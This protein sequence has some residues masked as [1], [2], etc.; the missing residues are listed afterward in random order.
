MLLTIFCAG[1]TLLQSWRM[2]SLTSIIMNKIHD[3]YSIS[4]YKTGTDESGKEW[5]T[6]CCVNMNMKFVYSFAGQN[7]IG[8]SSDKCDNW[9][10]VRIVD[11]LWYEN[12]L[13]GV[14]L[15]PKT[16]LSV[17]EWTVFITKSPRLNPLYSSKSH[18]TEASCSNEVVYILLEAGIYPD[19]N[20]IS[21][22]TAI[23]SVSLDVL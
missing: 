16:H 15:L 21:N 18:F 11:S 13:R 22:G 6:L 2:R 8:A 1:A 7:S 14:S 4:F 10:N 9:K 3:N 19:I 23:V 17:N 5:L 20:S 12:V